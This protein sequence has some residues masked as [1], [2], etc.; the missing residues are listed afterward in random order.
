MPLAS[1]GDS[2]GSLRIPAA[3]CGVV[4]F[5]GTYGRIPRGPEAWFRPGQY[6]TITMSNG[7]VQIKTVAKALERGCFGQ[8]VRVRNETTK[9]FFEVVMTGPQT[10]RIGG[11]ASVATV[12]RN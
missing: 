1:G 4:G 10:A 5:K 9:E 8:T 12:D 3:F 6:V 7:T 2:G 11:D